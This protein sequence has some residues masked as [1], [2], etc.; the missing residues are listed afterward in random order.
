MCLRIIFASFLC[1]SIVLQL[2]LIIIKPWF[3]SFIISS[4]PTSIPSLLLPHLPQFFSYFQNRTCTEA[5]FQVEVYE[6]SFQMSHHTHETGSEQESCAYFTPAM[7][8]V[9]GWFQTAQRSMFLPYF[10]VRVF[11]IDDSWYVGKKVWSIFWILIFFHCT[12]LNMCSNL[13]G[14][15]DFPLKPCRW[16]TI[17]IAIG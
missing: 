13:D 15:S 3:Q 16:L 7:Q 11:K 14:N 6:I 9:Q 4:S 1:D 5:P 2:L 10:L 8:S 17:L 12:S